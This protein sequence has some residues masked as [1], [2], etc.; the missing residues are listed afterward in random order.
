MPSIVLDFVNRAASGE[1]QTDGTRR[2]V[3]RQRFQT[4][5][6]DLCEPDRVTAA[7]RILNSVRYDGEA[8]LVEQGAVF[9][10]IQ[11]RVVQRLAFELPHGPGRR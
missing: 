9:G 8:I 1:N 6:P 11:A 4:C 2:Q 3:A 10:A 5:L 7:G